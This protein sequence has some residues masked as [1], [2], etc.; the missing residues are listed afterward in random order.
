MNLKSNF[1]FISAFLIV[2]TCFC[3][4]QDKQRVETL[5]LEQVKERI[6]QDYK[7]KQRVTVKYR[8]TCKKVECLSKASG[9]IKELGPDS[10]ILSDDGF[11]GWDFDETI[12]YSDVTNITKQN[13]GLRIAS[14]IGKNALGV[15]LIP[16]AVAMGIIIMVGGGI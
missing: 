16:P 8:D 7:N 4:G 14:I 6:N 10:F 2:M 1:L 15:V 5:S 13:N 11:F 12:N 9:K 3:Y